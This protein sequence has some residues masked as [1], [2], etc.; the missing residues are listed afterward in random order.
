MRK[1][2]EMLTNNLVSL[3]IAVAFI[4]I[5]I[6]LI[7]NYLKPGY[8]ANEEYAKAQLGA[9]EEKIK[10]VEGTGDL[11]EHLIIA[12]PENSKHF[13]VYFGDGHFT[14]NIIIEEEELAIVAGEA[15]TLGTPAVIKTFSY[16]GNKNEYSLCECY[17]ESDNSEDIRKIEPICDP[18]ISLN[19]P[20]N[21]LETLEL[22]LQTTLQFSK[23]D[24][25]III[26]EIK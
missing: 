11:Q 19:S 8:D 9:I 25:E 24:G 3:I 2:G 18:C 10:E 23:K 17:F 4:M 16:P 22:T 5:L 14:N 21:N 20:I 12:T 15:S 1:K 6:L 7:V 13:L 26:N